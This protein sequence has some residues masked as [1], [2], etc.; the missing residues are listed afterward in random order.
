MSDCLNR[1]LIVF[2]MLVL[3]GIAFPASAEVSPP[4]IH[5]YGLKACESYTNTIKERG[6]GKEQAI[7]HYLSYQD[8]LSG[9]VTGLSLATDMDVLHGVGVEGALRRI[10]VHCDDHPTD[11]FFTASMNLIKLLS[12]LNQ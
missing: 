2:L 5:G 7:A 12:N 8:W 6:E 3:I 4:S 9:L 11:D 10:Q 1:P